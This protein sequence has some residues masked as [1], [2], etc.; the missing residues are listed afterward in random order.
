MD[1]LGFFDFQGMLYNHPE[2]PV[3]VPPEWVD[4]F[5][6]LYGPQVA[7]VFASAP[8][9]YDGLSGLNALVSDASG[10][11]IPFQPI[12]SPFPADY[13]A[14]SSQNLDGLLGLF[15]MDFLL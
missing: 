6:N 11:L 4:F 9:F 13:A 3:S 1:G 14:A 15:G 10:G 12:V 2:S 8:T 7:G 5:Y